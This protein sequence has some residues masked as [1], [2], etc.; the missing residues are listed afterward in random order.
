MS[1]NFYLG[2]NDLIVACDMY[3]ESWYYKDDKWGKTIYQ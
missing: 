1:Y 2:L 3:Q